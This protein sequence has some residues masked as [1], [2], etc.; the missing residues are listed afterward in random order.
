MR[1]KLFKIIILIL[2]ILFFLGAFSQ[3]KSFIKPIS[4]RCGQ[5]N[6]NPDVSHQ[7]S[8]DCSGFSFSE[9]T[10]GSTN[11]Y[12]FGTCKKCEC[13]NYYYENQTRKVV[14]CSKL[15][16]E[17]QFLTNFYKHK[18]FI[19]KDMNKKRD[20]YSSLW[21]RQGQ[22]TLFIILGIVILVVFLSHLYCQHNS[23]RKS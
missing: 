12:C 1:M 6:F 14:D 19:L 7:K 13:S 8:C 5:S 16:P 15:Y 18:L 2:L 22:I 9:I 23:E 21:S 11:N 17:N 3:W 4:D 20:D 10:M